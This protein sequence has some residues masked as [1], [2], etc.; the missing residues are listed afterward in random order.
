MRLVTSVRIGFTDRSSGER[1]LRGLRIVLGAVFGPVVVGR[2]MFPIAASFDFGSL[3][4]F[5]FTVVL[6]CFAEGP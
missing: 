4:N 6:L 2:A 5:S 3:A 1:A